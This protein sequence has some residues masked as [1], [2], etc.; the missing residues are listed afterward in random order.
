MVAALAALSLSAAFAD[1]P[2]KPA[3][4]PFV[5]PS[6]LDTHGNTRA[7][8]FTPYVAAVQSAPAATYYFDC[9]LPANAVAD[10][11]FT[12]PFS[13]LASIAGITFQPGDNLMLR[14]GVTCHGQLLLQ[15]SGSI[16]NPVVVS[17]YQATSDDKG[18][19]VVN[20]RS[21]NY[22]SGVE[23]CTDLYGFD[24]AGAAVV[25]RNG[26]YW[27][28]KDLEV[29][30]VETKL[31]SPTNWVA[32]DSELIPSGTV[33]GPKITAHED[34]RRGLAKV[35][36]KIL[37]NPDLQSTYY[38]RLDTPFDV[39][40]GILVIADATQ[41]GSSNSMSGIQ[42][43][44]VYVHD[45]DGGAAT[46]KNTNPVA[47]AVS[48]LNTGNKT[49][50]SNGIFVLVRGTAS[51]T[52]IRDVT[53]RDSTI[54]RVG[55]TGL[56]TW[57]D[58]NCRADYKCTDTPNPGYL[59][60]E[61]VYFYNN[62]LRWIWGDGLIMRATRYG[63][64]ERNA[65]DRTAQR[66]DHNVALWAIH[67]EY[68]TF[69]KNAVQYTGKR[70]GNYDGQAFD[71]D[72][73]NNNITFENNYTYKNE[74]GFLLICGKCGGREGNNLVVRNNISIDDATS[75]Y[76]RALIQDNG[77][78]TSRT[79]AGVADNDNIYNHNGARFY[80][81]TFIRRLNKSHLIT[82]SKLPSSID[83][84]NNLIYSTH[85]GTLYTH[86][87]SVGQKNTQNFDVY[88]ASYDVP[89][90]SDMT[91]QACVSQLNSIW[92][93]F[94][95]L[96][97]SDRKYEQSD[98]DKDI[99]TF[100]KNWNNSR[101]FW[102]NN[103]LYFGSNL[104]TDGIQPIC[105]F[106]EHNVVSGRQLN[107]N[108]AGVKVKGKYQVVDLNRSDSIRTSS[109]LQD[110]NQ[111]APTVF[112]FQGKGADVDVSTLKGFQLHPS[113][114]ARGQGSWIMPAGAEA[115]TDFFGVN[116]QPTTAMPSCP[117]DIGAHQFT[118]IPTGARCN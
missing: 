113:S 49:K 29:T 67:S 17:A 24:A 106:E 59:P 9:S 97:L 111:T 110:P 78:G 43:E 80:N 12:R 98:I 104:F 75:K 18:R 99:A 52:T 26:S 50:T 20:G 8:S 63:R 89:A 70:P 95:S 85:P 60:F 37:T 4:G 64:V 5:V 33:S 56:S 73:S 76:A 71:F 66:S 32:N 54:E 19:P 28:I 93:N 86:W 40:N 83:F 16:A 114:P 31:V 79:I 112:E 109:I 100:D 77:T 30:N 84:R 105:N 22:L 11:S 90:K 38:W 65:A 82:D 68:L 15:G 91:K 21:C 55:R 46:T 23:T 58:F 7:S 44:N 6:K 74:G 42:I 10:G 48:N 108:G 62:Q 47:S 103:Y 87:S 53:V 57:T 94:G 96:A 13:R 14:R 39:R 101:L 118:A 115:S 72:F 92:S 36:D 3:N 116:K 61:Q 41:A 81:N 45:I 35:E 27:T 69:A 88:P 117:V 1:V 51:P 34:W 2:P 107:K 102:K 25:L